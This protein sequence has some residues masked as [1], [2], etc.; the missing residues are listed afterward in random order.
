MWQGLRGPPRYLPVAEPVDRV[1]A[2]EHGGE[3]D[4]EGEC[5]A[6]FLLSLR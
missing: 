5:H 2:D 1:S 6:V 3:G 4:Y